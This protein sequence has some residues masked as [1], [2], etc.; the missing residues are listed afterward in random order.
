MTMTAK[1]HSSHAYIAFDRLIRS[2]E[3]W[4]CSS[5]PE[6]LGYSAKALSARL[7]QRLVE[8]GLVGY[9]KKYVYIANL[10]GAAPA[11][12]EGINFFGMHVNGSSRR[13]SLSL[14]LI[15]QSV[16]EFFLHWIHVASI[17]IYACTSDTVGGKGKATLL[18]GV[19]SE[20][21]FLN[22]SDERFTNFCRKGS[23]LA[24]VNASRL[25]VQA[26]VDHVSID[27]QHFKYA[28]FPLFALLKENPPSVSEVVKLFMR[29]F[30]GMA[31]YF[32]AIF[33]CSP[34]SLLG[35][36]FAYHAL[37]EYLNQKNLIE[38][39]VI[40]NSN[41]SV[42]PLWMTDLPSRGFLTHMVWYAQNTVPIVYANDPVI[43][44]F[45]NYRHIRVD[46][47]WV[48][49]EEY[50]AYLK[51]LSVPGEMKIVGSILWYLRPETMP[52]KLLN[53][54][55]LIAFDVTPITN[56]F[57]EEVAFFGNY[58]NADN[59]RAF[60]LGVTVLRETLGAKLGKRV[61]LLLKHKRGYSSKHAPEYIALVRQLCLQDS[62]EL[63]P[64]E[65]NMY[66]LL[67][68][69]DLV[70]VIPYSSPALVAN[71]MGVPAVYFDPSSEVLPIYEKAEGIYFAAGEDSLTKLAL[72]LIPMDGTCTQ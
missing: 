56:E 42:Q 60:L 50:A 43:A 52:K 57:A 68:I 62:V 36:D 31:A 9:V 37:V 1:F 71:S 51:S 40:T 32:T 54:I 15:L 34:I 8:V 20:H 65:T 70:V 12:L 28:R 49:T 30:R 53:E 33:R 38:N 26:S 13:I 46:C 17:I 10:T 16:F 44:A 63:V 23:I 39:V 72:E 5:V 14:W 21:C 22:E 35:R 69:A 7:I 47:S 11:E 67:A 2:N 24:L 29:H 18:F 45:P 64:F 4:A 19:G 25:I 3:A 6:S 66:S 59:M 55:T 61:K 48:W 58:Y 27:P 41:Y